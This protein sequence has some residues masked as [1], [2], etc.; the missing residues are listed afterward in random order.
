MRNERTEPQHRVVA[1]I[2]SAITLP[3]GAADGVGAHAE[4]HA[5]LEDAGKRAGRRQTD[6]ESLQYPE[7][8]VRFHD[9]DETKD[10]FGGHKTIGIKR[11]REFVFTA[12]PFAE[13]ADITRLVT[14]VD[15][16]PPVGHRDA[17]PPMLGQRT[18][19]FLLDRRDVWVAG[20]TQH[21]DMET[22]TEPRLRE[23][24]QHRLEIANHPL[25]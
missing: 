7:L 21:I 22:D 1:P 8:G 24:G 18:E 10:G 9:P 19:T 25:W 20:V 13:I 16:A 12:P 11:H 2:G 23:A 3:P 5:E 17:V 14:G 4:P 15:G 6:D